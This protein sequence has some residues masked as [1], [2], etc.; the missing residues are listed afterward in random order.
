METDHSGVRFCSS[1]E[2][3]ARG[4]L[5]ERLS[6]RHRPRGGLY[7]LHSAMLHS[8]YYIYIYIYICIHIYIYI[9][10]YIYTLY[11]LHSVNGSVY[12]TDLEAKN[13]GYYKLLLSLLCVCVLVLLAPEPLNLRLSLLLAR[14]RLRLRHRP[15]GGRL[16]CRT[17][18][19]T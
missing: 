10:I 11:I 8:T 2:D 18:S 6:L 16:V 9:Y 14:E 19:Y 17:S 3:G 5:R 4:R 13:M 1:S 15:R 7:I 12:G